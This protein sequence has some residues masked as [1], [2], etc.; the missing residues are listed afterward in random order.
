MKFARTSPVFFLA[1]AALVPT[2]GAG[3]AGSQPPG[4]APARAPSVTRDGDEDAPRRIVQLVGGHVLRGPARA[5]AGGAIEVRTRTGVVRAEAGSIARVR[6]EREVLA[7]YAQLARGIDARDFVRRISLCAWLAEAGLG[8]ELLR[9]LDVVL[10]ADPDQKRA[11]DLARGTLAAETLPAQ[12]ADPARER[13]RALREA[14]RAAP[15]TREAWIARIE[16]LVQD[17]AAAREALRVALVDELGQGVDLR[18]FCAARVLRRVLPGVA[19][20]RLEALALGDRSRVARAEARR[21]LRDARDPA[22]VKRLATRVEQGALK[23]RIGAIDTLAVVADAAAVPALAANLARLATAKPA[24]AGAGGGGT[25]RSHF[26]LRRQV[27]YTQDFDV[28]IAQAASIAD[29]IVAYAEEGVVL[30]VSTATWQLP[31]VIEYE[32]ALTCGALAR[33]VGEGAKWKP[34]EWLAWWEKNRARFSTTSGAR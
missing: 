1:L 11:L 23:E 6:A 21:A 15:A 14:G 28:E 3:A 30:D 24:A 22:V 19:T 33:I 13:A 4:A 32:N 25:P 10:T 7:E 8:S 26:S 18:R 29:P 12:E 34:A 16:R 31:V 20:E 27:A 9:E 5:L 2:S 17:D